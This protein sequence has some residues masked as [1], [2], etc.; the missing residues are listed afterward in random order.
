MGK[1]KWKVGTAMLML[2]GIDVL[3]ISEHNKYAGRADI[4]GAAIHIYCVYALGILFTLIPILLAFGLRNVHPRWF[5]FSLGIGIAW[6]ILSPIFFFVP[7]AWDG[8]YE[9]FL[10]LLMISWVIAISWLL[11]WRGNGGLSRISSK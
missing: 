7:T 8:A 9:R 2:L 5:T 1:A 4:S 6:A 11:F 3:L 10:A